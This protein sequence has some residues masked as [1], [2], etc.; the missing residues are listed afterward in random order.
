MP[1]TS[2]FI[3][4]REFSP[5]A[6]GK[7]PCPPKK[8]NY[9]EWKEWQ[10]EQQGRCYNGFT[11][12]G[13]NIIGE[14]YLYLNFL[15]ILRVPD[16][17][18]SRKQWLPP[19]FIDLD[20]DKFH[21]YYKARY[22]DK[23]R[24]MSITGSRQ[25]G[26]TFFSGA[27][28]AY[29]GHMFPKSQ[30][31]VIGYD[32]EFAADTFRLIISYSDQLLETE[33]RK[34]RGLSNKADRL[35]FGKKELDNDSGEWIPV[36][37]LSE[38]HKLV[39]KNNPQC[40][41]GKTPSLVLR[42]ESG[43]FNNYEAQADY[44]KSQLE[45]EGQYTG[46]SLDFG[47]GGAMT[48]GGSVGLK[49]VHNKPAILDYAEYDEQWSDEGDYIEGK[50]RMIGFFIPAWRG[51]I[52]DKDGN[53]NKELSL[54]KMD[55]DRAEVADDPQA[56][57]NLCS[58]EPKNDRESFYV[59]GGNTLPVMLLNKRLAEIAGDPILQNIIQKGDLEWVRDPVSRTILDVK[60]IPN[61][62]TGLYQILE[63][64]QWTEIS[65][66]IKKPNRITRQNSNGL[67]ISGCDSYDADVSTTD[68]IGSM[69]VYKRFLN[70]DITGN[71]FVAEYTGRPD[72][73]DFYENTAKLNWYYNS[74]MLFEA[75]NLGIKQW[76]INNNMIYVLKE[77]PEVAYS[78]IKDSR[79][80]Y[81]YGL[82]M[83]DPIKAFCTTE[84]KKWIKL[85]VHHL[86][87]TDQ[88][89]DFIKFTRDTNHDRTIASMLCIVQDLDN[90][91]ISEQEQNTPE[92]H[93]MVSFK[94]TNGKLVHA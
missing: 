69:F 93:R 83:P 13:V 11:V 27:I 29:E 89:E 32:E 26:K 79:A 67:Y 57:Y 56:Y 48:S 55:K 80:D 63:H 92:E 60:W 7:E 21:S 90:A 84:M 65:T 47:T 3:N 10:A 22:V 75:T 45:S 42:E 44:M 72:A 24:G 85:W 74:R 62:K 16:N 61:S 8:T 54:A 68:S 77:K 31:L 34:S 78:N 70:A 49:K 53:S 86:F 12:G 30:T 46:F 35:I 19:R 81:T 6:L 14:H 23:K 91:R 4:T 40:S 36:G 43:K 50:G 58:Q 38:I 1:C 39:A 9:Y 52:M 41:I 73:I 25:R 28:G 71:L 20:Y 2:G 66:D 15:K 88:I 87:F 37:F 82:Q 76:Y 64:P 51:L 94:R 59:Q 33:F 18:G 17:G 5:V